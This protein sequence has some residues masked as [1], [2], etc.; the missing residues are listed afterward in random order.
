V[1]G[2]SSTEMR[3]RECACTSATDRDPRENA[4]RSSNSACSTG[5][6]GYCTAK[7]DIAP[8]TNGEIELQMGP[9]DSRDEMNGI[10][11]F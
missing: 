7:L 11:Y 4:K 1:N 3:R 6:Y 2:D 8:L 9:A 10:P 5:I